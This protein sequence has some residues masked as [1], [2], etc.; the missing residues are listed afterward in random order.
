MRVSKYT[1]HLPLYRQ[2][3][4]YAREGVELERSTLAGRVGGAA[5]LLAPLLSALK[6]HVLSA[7]KLHG[8]DTPVGARTGPGPIP[9]PPGSGSMSAMNGPGLEVRRRQCRWLSI[10]SNRQSVEER[11][12]ADLGATRAV[13]LNLPLAAYATSSSTT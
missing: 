6:R 7:D 1:D 8:N 10:H 4:I 9:R 5:A 2:S 13:Q 3:E 12:Y 11:R